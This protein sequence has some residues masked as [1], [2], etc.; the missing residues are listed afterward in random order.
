MP[1]TRTVAPLT[2]AGNIIVLTTSGFTVLS[3]NYDTPTA[4]PTIASVVNAADGAKP[5][6]PGGLIS[7]YGTNMSATNMATSQMPLPTALAQSCL[8]VTG[9][10]RRSCL[11]PRDK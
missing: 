8:V 3:G 2:S 11:S 4:P 1:F 6:A 5:V 9:R 10:L 7:I